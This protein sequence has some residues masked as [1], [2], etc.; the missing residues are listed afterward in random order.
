MS[1]GVCR[2][3]TWLNPVLL[4]CRPAAAAPIKPLVWEFPYAVATAV[5][6]KNKQMKNLA[7]GI[8]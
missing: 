1:C 6:D 8:L 2:L 3:Q 5:I 4:W 7:I